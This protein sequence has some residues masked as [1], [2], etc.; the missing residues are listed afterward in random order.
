MTFPSNHSCVPLEGKKFLLCLCVSALRAGHP[1]CILVNS[2]PETARILLQLC[3]VRLLWHRWMSDLT[4]VMFIEPI[5]STL[6]LHSI[7]RDLEQLRA[8]RLAEHRVAYLFDNIAAFQK[9]QRGKKKGGGK[10]RFL[11]IAQNCLF[12][13]KHVIWNFR[14]S[15]TFFP[16]LRND[17]SFVFRLSYF[18]FLVRGLDSGGING[19][20]NAF[21]LFCKSLGQLSLPRTL[22]WLWW[23]CLEPQFRELFAHL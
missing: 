13:P 14:V 16:K 7:W 19:L 2:K 1:G 9:L 23:A 3:N 10:N 8:C 12:H 15:V 4:R 6:P 22:G 18:V 21:I 17:C 20:M 11:Q 5:I